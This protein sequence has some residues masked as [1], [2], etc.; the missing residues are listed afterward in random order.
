MLLRSLYDVLSSIAPAKL[1]SK[2]Y[3]LKPM[4]EGDV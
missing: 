3:S 4:A 1:K 2:V